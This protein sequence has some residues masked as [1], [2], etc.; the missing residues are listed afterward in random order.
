MTRL[1]LRLVARYAVIVL[2]LG[3]AVGLVPA[4]FAEDGAV[5]PTPEANAEAIAEVQTHANYLWTIIAACMVFLMQAGFALV[6]TGLS[7]FVYLVLFT[8]TFFLEGF[9]GLTVTIFC[10]LTLF[11]VMPLTGRLDWSEQFRGGKKSA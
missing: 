4:A 7:Q 3:L 2:V 10:I 11:L 9:T 6:E 5:P 1:D 8:Y